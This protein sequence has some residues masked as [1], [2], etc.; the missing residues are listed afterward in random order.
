MTDSREEL[1]RRLR[2]C[3][4]GLFTYILIAAN[5]TRFALRVPLW[6]LI[7]GEVVNLGVITALVVEIRRIRRKINE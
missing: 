5:A 6:V 4:V 7:V 1:H 3:W 2:L